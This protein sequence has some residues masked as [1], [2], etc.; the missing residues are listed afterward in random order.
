MGSVA[1]WSQAAATGRISFFANSVRET[2]DLFLL[3]GDVE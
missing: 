3:V 1:V 2:L